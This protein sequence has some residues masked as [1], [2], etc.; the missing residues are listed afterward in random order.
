M[1][2]LYRT[3]ILSAQVGFEGAYGHVLGHKLIVYGLE[4]VLVI[5]EKGR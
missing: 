1:E 4:A 3:V 2:L 5:L